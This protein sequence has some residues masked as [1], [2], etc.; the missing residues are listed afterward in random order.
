MK[1]MNL[2]EQLVATMQHDEM[3]ESPREWSNLGTFTHGKVEYVSR[4]NSERYEDYA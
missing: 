2:K 4:Y 3:P 1:F